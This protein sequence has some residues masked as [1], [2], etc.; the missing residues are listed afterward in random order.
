MARQSLR[1]SNGNVME[2]LAS[3][4][5]TS[6][7]I[8]GDKITLDIDESIPSFDR[9]R[10]WFSSSM[11]RSDILFT[12][13]I[14]V[15]KSSRQ[16]KLYLSSWS[17]MYDGVVKTIGATNLHGK[18]EHPSYQENGR[19]QQD[20]GWGITM[21]KFD[22]P[23]LCRKQNSLQALKWMVNILHKSISTSSSNEGR[24]SIGHLSTTCVVT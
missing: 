7:I 19:G 18:L 3:D 20:W 5:I 9:V 12:N 16:E 6:R 15:K 10:R 2:W 8:D 11:T 17:G 22:G 23:I 1:R 21:S 14:T 13:E 24:P 4:G